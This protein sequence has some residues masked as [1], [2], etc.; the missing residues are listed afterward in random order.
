MVD[1]VTVV[2][3]VLVVVVSSSV[4]I[5][6]CLVLEGCPVGDLVRFLELTGFLEGCFIGTLE[7]CFVGFFDGGLVGF[8]VG[9]KKGRLGLLGHG[10]YTGWLFGWIL[11]GDARKVVWWDSWKAAWSAPWLD[12]WYVLVLLVW[13]YSRR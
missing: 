13:L 12:G 11:G 6:R 5:G 10:R 9:F 8:L 1:V 4:C 2:A 3:V 7:G